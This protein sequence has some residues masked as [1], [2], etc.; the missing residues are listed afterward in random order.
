MI[1]HKS[2]KYIPQLTNIFLTDAAAAAHFRINIAPDSS[3]WVETNGASM[4]L[5]IRNT[6]NN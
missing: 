4:T 3:T 1:T 6:E 5:T 2:T